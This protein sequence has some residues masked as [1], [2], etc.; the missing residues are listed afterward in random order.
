MS[1]VVY[2]IDP[3]DPIKNPALRNLWIS[4]QSA[5]RENHG[6]FSAAVSGNR[7]Y[8]LPLGPHLS[9]CETTFAACS[10]PRTTEIGCHWTSHGRCQFTSSSQLDMTAV[11]SLSEV[12][13]AESTNFTHRKLENMRLK[14]MECEVVIPPRPSDSENHVRTLPPQKPAALTA[15]RPGEGHGSDA[16]RSERRSAHGILRFP[17]VF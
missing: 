2:M 15:P 1:D 9:Y 6:H 7:S 10:P 16:H 4:K 12:D 8:A 14:P 5:G 11:C 17:F 3:I 13:A